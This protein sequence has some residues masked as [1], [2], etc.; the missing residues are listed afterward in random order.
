MIRDTFFSMHRFVDVCRKE[1][2]ENWK[3]YILRS[4][5][6]YGMLAIIFIWDGYFDYKTIDAFPQGLADPLWR[7]EA[8]I[9]L[10]AFVI[11]GCISASFAMERMKTKTSRTV[12]LMTPATMFEKYFSRWLIAICGFLVV[13]LIAFKMADWTRVVVYM[14]KYPGSDVISSFPLWQFWT[15]SGAFYEVAGGGGPDMLIFISAFSLAQSFFMLGS[16]VW[17]KNALIKTFSAGISIVVVYILFSVMMG[18]IFLTG[19]FFID[20]TG[21]DKGVIQTVVVAV[22]FFFTLFNWVLAYFRFKE[23]EI[24]NRW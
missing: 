5:M 11:W 20:D 9:F 23:S 14:L 19:D 4:I 18:K 17:P 24:I 12:V 3:T 1:M 7:F 16:T 22:N 21:V 10:F 15:N 6:V 13:F 8:R 2:V